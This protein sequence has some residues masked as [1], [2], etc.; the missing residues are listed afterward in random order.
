M[1]EIRNIRNLFKPAYKSGGKEI[2]QGHHRMI[3][4]MV[5]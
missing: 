4:V 2:E 5:K 3:I 1:L